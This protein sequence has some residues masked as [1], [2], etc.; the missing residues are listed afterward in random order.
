[1]GDQ[2][3]PAPMQGQPPMGKPAARGIR[4]R[5]RPM[6]GGGRV[7]TSQGHK[8][9]QTLAICRRSPAGATLA[10]R[11]AARKG[12]RLLPAGT[13]PLEVPP[14]GA[15]PTTWGDDG[16]PQKAKVG[17]AAVGGQGNYR[18]RRGDCGD[19]GA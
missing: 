7:R 10:C 4:L 18:P 6:Q 16:L 11:S 13:A 14:V 8:G 3:R 9:R 5:P 15:E 2:P 12:C 19:D 17:R 1:M